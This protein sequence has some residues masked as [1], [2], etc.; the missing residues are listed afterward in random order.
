[1]G[2]SANLDAVLMTNVPE[3]FALN[4]SDNNLKPDGVP[5]GLSD[6]VLERGDRWVMEN[7]IGITQDGNGGSH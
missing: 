5:E 6:R 2:G 4:D 7:R 3:P 1:M